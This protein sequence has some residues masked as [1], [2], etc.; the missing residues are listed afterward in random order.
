[1]ARTSTDALLL[2]RLLIVYDDKMR[3]PPSSS[4]SLT[5]APCITSACILRPACRMR[6]R[7]RP[8]RKGFFE[9]GILIPDRLRMNSVQEKVT[10]RW[11]DHLLERH[12]EVRE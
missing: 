7:I 10:N 3:R 5:H 4:M 9:G 6:R 11:L 8:S 12:P 1:M 2:Q